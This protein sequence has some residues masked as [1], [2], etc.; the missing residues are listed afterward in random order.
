M[1]N[2]RLSRVPTKASLMLA[3]GSP[4]PRERNANNDHDGSRSDVG[5]SWLLRWHTAKASDSPACYLI[6]ILHL[7]RSTGIL[8]VFVWYPVGSTSDS[9]IIV[10]KFLWAV[11]FACHSCVC[12]CVCLSVDVCSFCFVLLDCF[13]GQMI[14][15]RI[16]QRKNEAFL[17]NSSC[18][19]MIYWHRQA[20][21]DRLR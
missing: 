7:S 18:E 6:R 20:M 2:R 16:V 17:P 14:W 13:Q 10:A 21:I 5:S 3:V 9:E 8:S 19:R 15:N 12:V 11:V 1:L 4:S